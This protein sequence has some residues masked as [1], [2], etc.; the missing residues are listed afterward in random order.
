MPPGANHRAGASGS[1]SHSLLAHAQR[2]DPAA[3]QRLVQLYAPLVASW[4]R[5]WGI[6][7]QDIADLLQDVFTAVAR[8]LGHFRKQQPHDTFRGWLVTIARNK[9]RDYYRRQGGQPAAFGGTE[10]TLRIAQLHDPLANDPL[11]STDADDA[12]LEDDAAFGEVLRRSLETIR[13]EFE[14]RTWQA[15]WSVVVEGRSAEE[16]G[17]RLNMRPG[18]VRVAKSRVLHRLRRELGD[19]Y[20]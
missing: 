9:V 2:D 4:C 14:E 17:A 18:N 11:A 6:P 12:G 13:G 20:E 1:T 7:N 16:T 15:F 10:A 19:V 3:W 5:R 8:N